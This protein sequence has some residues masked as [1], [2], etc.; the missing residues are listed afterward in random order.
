MERWKKDLQ[1]GKTNFIMQASNDRNSGKINITSRVLDH[2]IS[3]CK[4]VQVHL[5]RNRR[6]EEKMEFIIFALPVLALI[7]LV[8]SIIQFCRT[9][10]EDTEKR[11]AFRKQIVISTV[12]IAA[13]LAIIGGFIIFLIHSFAVNGM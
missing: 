7:W 5:G 6:L 11:K 13:W 10:K 2:L 9:N 12:L 8:F 3:F 1:K 4:F